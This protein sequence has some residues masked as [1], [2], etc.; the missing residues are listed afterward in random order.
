MNK[1]D[2]NRVPSWAFNQININK[3]STNKQ[4]V[5]VIRKINLISM[6]IKKKS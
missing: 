6:K 3:I 2:L 4:D 5:F 1:T